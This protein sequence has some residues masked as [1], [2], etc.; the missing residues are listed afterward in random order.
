M[1]Y[2][3]ENYIS[4]FLFK[5]TLLFLFLLLTIS[6]YD[7]QV[8]CPE[9]IVVNAVVTISPEGA[10]FCNTFAEVIATFTAFPGCSGP[11]VNSFTSNGLNASASYPLGT[12]T[13]IFTACPGAESGD[14][15]QVDVTILPPPPICQAQ[16]RTIFL[17][18]NGMVTLEPSTLYVSGEPPVCETVLSF[19]TDMTEFDCDDYGNNTVTLTVTDN[20]GQ[21]DN[22]TAQVTVQDEIAPTCMLQDITVSLGASGV[23][24]P[25]SFTDIDNGSSDN[26]CFTSTISPNTFDCNNLSCG[27]SGAIVLPPATVFVTLTDCNNTELTTGC[28]A[29]VTVMDNLP[30]IC[31]AKDITIDLNSNN[32]VATV[33]G[34]QIDDGSTDNCPGI[35]YLINEQN[36]IALDCGDIGNVSVMLTVTDACGNSSNCSANIT[37]EAPSTSLSC[38][39][40]DIIVQL[41][42]L[43]NASFL[44]AD[45]DDGSSSSCGNINLS[46]MPTSFSCTEIG[47]NSVTLTI[48]DDFG[49]SASCTSTVTIEDNIAPTCNAQDVT[50][51]LASNGEVVLIPQVA[52][53]AAIN[54]LINTNSN[55]TDAAS[56][57]GLCCDIDG[58]GTEEIIVSN[59]GAIVAIYD[60]GNFV[61][62]IN[63]SS[64][65]TLLTI[66]G[67]YDFSIGDINNDGQCDLIVSKFP[68]LTDIYF[69]NNGAFTLSTTL[70]GG[71]VD[72]GCVIDYDFDGDLDIINTDNL[73]FQIFENNGSGVFGAP[74]IEVLS[75]FMRLRDC[76]DLDSDGDID[77]VLSPEASVGSYSLLETVG[78]NSFNEIQTNIAF[79][80]SQL[81]LLDIDND[82]D[83]DYISSASPFNSI[84]YND[85]T[86]LPNHGAFDP[87]LYNNSVEN[88]GGGLSVI[89]DE[90]FSF[91]GL[92]VKDINNDGLDDL[93]VSSVP[94][95]FLSRNLPPGFADNCPNPTIELSQELF[96]CDDKPEVNEVTITVTDASGNSSECTS[97][98]TVVDN[99]APSCMAKDITVTLINSNYTLS[100]IEIDNA[101][102]DNCNVN[103]SIPPTTFDCSNL[104]QN[105]VTLT[106]DDGCGN[107]STCTSLVTVESNAMPT[108][109]TQDVTI[110]LDADGVAAYAAADIDNGSSAECGPVSLSASP[111]TF[112]CNGI[113]ANTVTLTVMDDN[114]N[115]SSCSAIVTVV[116]E[117]APVCT[118]PD[119]TV[120]LDAQGVVCIDTSFFRSTTQ[121]NLTPSY[122]DNCAVSSVGL[123]NNK[124]D[125]SNIG[126]NNEA[127][128]T[129]T[130]S[131]GN[132]ST[133]V[134]NVTVQD[135]LAPICPMNVDL[136]VQLEPG[137]CDTILA[138]EAPIAT[139]NCDPNPSSNIISQV[140]ISTGGSNDCPIDILFVMDN[141]G[142]ISTSEYNQMEASALAEK[143]L[144][145]ASFP[146]SRFATVHYFGNCGEELHI[147]NDFT[148]ASNITSITRQGTGNDDL[149]VALG[150]VMK[151]LDGVTDPNLFGGQLN[152]D[153]ASKFC[154]V[155]FTDAPRGLPSGSCTGTALIPYD[156]RNMLASNYGANFTVVHFD[157]N[158]TIDPIAA[159]IAS[160][161]GTWT[162]AVD[163]NPGDP[164]NGVIP[165]QYIPASFGTISLDLLSAIPLCTTPIDTFAIGTHVI[166]YEVEDASGN[167]AICSYNINVLEHVPNGILCMGQ[168]NFSLDPTTCS[169]S[170]TPEMLL[171]TTSDIGCIDSCTVTVRDEYGIVVP[172]LFTSDDINKTFSYEVCCG[173]L[174]CWGEVLVE[175]KFVPQLDCTGP[176]D[177]SCSALDQLDTPDLPK[178]TTCLTQDYEVRLLD[179]VRESLECHERYAS[180][181]TRTFGVIDADGKIVNECQQV[182][183]VLR[184]DL[185]NITFPESTTISCSEDRLLYYEQDGVQIPLPWVNT[186][187]GSMCVPTIPGFGVPVQCSGGG[188][189]FEDIQQ[190]IDFGSTNTKDIVLAD[191]NS[192]GFLDAF[193][194]VTNDDREVWFGDGSGNFSLSQNLGFVSF[195]GST[196]GE[197]IAVG[198]FN[199]DGFV[200]V[201]E[202]LNGKI[203]WLNDGSGMFNQSSQNFVNGVITLGIDV[204]DIDGDGWD[205]LI[206]ATTGT[207][208]AI[209]QEVW[210]NDQ[211]GNG[212]F[213]LDQTLLE[214]FS[215]SDVALGDLDGDGDLDAYVSNRTNNEQDEIYLYENGNFINSQQ[216]LNSQISFSVELGDLDGDGDLDAIVSTTSLLIYE[217]DGF[218]NMSLISQLPINNT[219]GDIELADFNADG[220]LDILS[221]R[222]GLIF[223]NLGNGLFDEIDLKTIITESGSAV[224]DI[225]N[226]GLPDIIN[227]SSPNTVLLNTS[228]PLTCNPLIPSSGVS[229]VNTAC[230]I[231]TVFG[232]TQTICN[233]LVTYTDVVVPGTSCRRKI[234]RTWEIRE[235]W[236]N[237]DSIIGDIQ[238]IEIIDDVAPTIV[239]PADFTVSTDDDCAGSVR[240]P[241]IEAVDDCGGNGVI[242]SVDYPLG[243]LN[244]NGGDAVLQVGNNLIRYI[245]ADSC[246]NDTTCM[247][248]VLVQDMT[249]PVAICES[250]TVVGIS[251]SGNSFIF[252]DALDD[253]SWDECGLDRFEVA[254][255]DS[256]CVA[257]DTLF[258]DKV[259][260]CCSDVGQEVMVIF[261]AIDKGGN[262]NDCMV[263]VEVQDKQVPLVTCPPND[264]IDCRVPY[265]LDN[266][267]LTFG[268]PDLN[269]NCP[270]T[271]N[272]VE[273]ITTDV[274]QCGIGTIFRKLNLIDTDSTILRQCVQTITVTN[275][276]P[277]LPIMIQWPLDIDTVGV[278]MT[279]DL[280]P[281]DLPTLSSFPT[282]LSGDDQCSLLGYDYKDEVF[283]GSGLG[284]CAYIE[285][286]WT[287]INWCEENSGITSQMVDLT[288]PQII[289]LRKVK[290]PQIETIGQDTVIVETTKIDCSS[291]TIIVVRTAVD[292]CPNALDWS[293][294]IRN[295]EDDVIA[296]GVSDTLIEVLNTGNYK[297]AWTVNDYCG[298]K[299]I[300]VQ[301]LQVINTKTPTPVCINGLSG[302]LV[303]ED[304]DGDGAI[305][306]EIFDLWASDVDG[307]SFHTCNNGIVLSFSSDTTIQNLLFD[308][309]DIG[310]QTIQLWVTDTITGMQDFC[311]TFIDIQD[312]GMC[313]DQF[314]VSVEG[315]VHT[316]DFEM[317]DKVEVELG[318]TGIMDMT[319]KDGLYAFEDMP[320]GGSYA[321][322]PTKDIDYLNGV[323][324]LDIIIIQRH[325]LNQEPLESAYKMIAA[326]INN[327]QDVS[328]IDLIELRKLILGV[329]DEL[330]DNDSWRFV[331]AEHTFVDVLNPWLIEM[332]ENYIISNLSSDM[333]IDFVGVKVGDVNGSVIANSESNKIEKRASRSG[334][335]LDVKEVVR[336]NTDIR[337]AQIS[338]SNYEGVT[339]LQSTIEFD[340]EQIEILDIVGQNISLDAN[341]YNL[342]KQSEGWIAISYEGSPQQAK[343]EE[344]VL[345]EIIYRMKTDK[346]NTEPFRMTSKVARSEAYV[347]GDQIIEVRMAYGVEE[348]IQIVSVSPNPWIDRAVIEFYIPQAGK[349]DWEFYDV[350]GKVLH[351]L[352]DTY[353]AGFNTIEIGRKDIQ[354]SGIVY[355]RLITDQGLL[356]Y[357]MI[358]I[359]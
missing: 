316:E 183:N 138:L 347:E 335:V 112:D 253:G 131:S 210:I 42:Q 124:F 284:A 160:T 182:Y 239:C 165:R 121:P 167:T 184:V 273:D 89:N 88:L 71:R 139:D 227:S 103:L 52:A 216:I 286:T 245:V 314:R 26:C 94:M 82:G 44:A 258:D 278:C 307:G 76:V 355:V 189:E 345:F 177:I 148:D 212:T 255:M 299:D 146:N 320:L 356:K 247:I 114:G 351:K 339:G 264:T 60:N 27:G 41:D 236:C 295:I 102:S 353:E 51:N 244:S 300:H 14:F 56:G 29:N 354:A 201:V 24:A 348:S 352:S 315:E 271:Q 39:T 346:V 208:N 257:Q 226:D 118:I 22:C 79:S 40:Q 117:I 83:L 334:L 237:G 192:D 283:E 1:L 279:S 50:I 155:I 301:D 288:G 16:N 72:G 147:E 298:N 254:R 66:S 11:V 222:S 203:I 157:P 327:S 336:P 64:S 140:G 270:S 329:Y 349:G 256:S 290:A 17:D 174:C 319:E 225:N 156:N 211:S 113:G 151:A 343:E 181:V 289:T 321:V 176:V 302:T 25:I 73:N 330:P 187:S 3:Y 98:V 190:S 4:K 313:P 358:V 136:T 116:D 70:L 163:N 143:N 268:G 129:V 269:D 232:S 62:D 15:C 153:P 287:V 59:N 338:S 90:Y 277:F 188:V 311:S 142:S 243:F 119:I 213:V 109:M 241:E 126:S 101:S 149:N 324:T 105:T 6:E 20:Y 204:G 111:T 84:A 45:I 33:T 296:T 235:W 318:T 166:D 340:S 168:V 220:M 21:S 195:G 8:V 292:D 275:D 7:A 172:N 61:Y 37:V 87:F 252:A 68:G 228:T 326:D 323:S 38:M 144:I 130:D 357:K 46:V 209:G 74:I 274:N 322:E 250:H 325:I 107:T 28:Q 234:L 281:E 128:V 169:G 120:S 259:A 12:T 55:L 309:D 75:D 43:G 240:L 115:S 272:I 158:A 305:D 80:S 97:M 31:L 294:T 36:S 93:L 100:A 229:T 249:E 23:S 34:S 133:C 215:A 217:N 328:T 150:L 85:G 106:A 122:T 276:A 19:S 32:G 194:A 260:F 251:Q 304:T 47:S 205:D 337:R 238:Q 132:M 5:N 219:S 125:C 164:D 221:D 185:S 104:G 10:L 186:G 280:K 332:P 306:T 191:F 178:I 69:N 246:Y 293:Y 224:G 49:N 214:P 312:A 230:E 54:D 333:E 261:R 342:T 110:F 218:S 231:D 207:G 175:Y 344:D 57:R 310:I 77:F 95:L 35:S 170:L 198:D 350:N 78:T 193:S 81:V 267:S 317:V 96:T 18:E 263:R 242:V 135:T 223:I 99:I 179:E 134:A 53:G 199:K 48:T 297:V 145:A 331:D 171:A 196:G 30:P 233:A 173:G 285:R 67:L 341:N 359:D 202:G 159:S 92:V 265:D 291:D 262:H 65:Q 180:T 127:T 282:F 91:R 206:F 162:G 266:L 197:T 141:S 108:C 161:G 200:D 13:V 137:Q 58:D 308:C 303:G 9:D 152:K 2:P 154:V 63:N 123:A 86:A 248:N